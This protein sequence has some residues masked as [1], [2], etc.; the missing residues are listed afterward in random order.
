MFFQHEKTLRV[1]YLAQR[2]AAQQLFRVAG[3][4]FHSFIWRIGEDDAEFFARR[5]AAPQKIEYILL[6]HARLE[7]HLGQIF[8]D[9][10]NR[11]LIF[12]YEK[13]GDGTA[14]ERLDA[15]CTASGKEIENACANDHISQAR[16]NR[17]FHAIHCWSYSCFWHRQPNAA[18]A[19]GDHPHGE[20]AG[21]AAPS[22]PFAAASASGGFF[23][24]DR[25]LLPPQKL[26]TKSLKSR[27]TTFSR[28]FDFGRSI[29]PLT[30]KSI[31]K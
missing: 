21:V 13:G 10:G 20:P 7:L 18:D 24:F 12:I 31:A 16:E 15:K 27:P 23:F 9:R 17:G 5:Q 28:R 6:T 26:F 11:S 29:V 14:A 19:T 8:L 2:L 3:S 25:S 22:V 4:R 30:R 1:E